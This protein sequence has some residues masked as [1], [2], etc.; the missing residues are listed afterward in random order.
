MKH[1]LYKDPPGHTVPFSITCKSVCFPVQHMH[2][3][4][5]FKGVFEC[6]HL[7][8]WLKLVWELCD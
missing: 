2:F 6:S 8:L 7:G 4:S 3:A 1:N 5:N